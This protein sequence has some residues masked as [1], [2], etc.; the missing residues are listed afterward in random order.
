MIVL[1]ELFRYRLDFSAKV[2]RED[3]FKLTIGNKSLCK[4]SNDNGVKVVN[5]AT[6]K[7]L[8]VKSTTFPHCNI[9]KYTLTSLDEKTQNHIDPILIDR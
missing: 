2:G 4:I 6:C 5:F 7:N 8:T 1:M 9:H 3:T